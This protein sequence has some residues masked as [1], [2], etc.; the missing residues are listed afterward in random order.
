MRIY[1]RTG[2]D[3]TTGLVGAR[4]TSKDDAV[5]EAIGTIDELNSAIGFVRAISA[6]SPLDFMLERLQNTLFE[7][8]A[9]VASDGSSRQSHQAGLVDKVEAL[10]RSM[11]SQNKLLPELREFVLPGGSELAARLH[12]ARTAARLA[13]RRLVA[14]SRISPVR[15]ELLAFLNRLSDWMFVA[16]RTANNEACLPDV[17][18]IKEN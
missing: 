16:A 18:W 5:I 2:D 11:D 17:V 8:G 6:D 15:S 10:E 9:E 7:I 13:E 3:G 12:L 14:Y 4:R 1:T